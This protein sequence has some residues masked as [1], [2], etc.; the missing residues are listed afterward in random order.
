MPGPEAPSL[1][2][3][4]ENFSGVL[5]VVALAEDT[6]EVLALDG[7]RV[8]PTASVIK[9][10]ILAEVF[11]QEQAG[12]LSLSEPVTLGEA[13][14]AGGSGVLKDLSAGL[15]LP[16]L[17]YATLMITVSDNTATNMLIDRLGGIAA[18][19]R[20]MGEELGL[21]TITLRRK[22]TIAP[23]A[24][25][26][27]SRPPLGA[28]SPRQLAELVSLIWQRRLV[29]PRASEHMLA[30]L[31]RQQYLDQVP[32]LLDCHLLATQ[33]EPPAGIAV[34]NKT[35][36]ADGARADAGLLLLHGRAVSYAVMSASLDT[37]LHAD[38]DGMLANAAAGVAI[39]ER[40]WPGTGRPPVRAARAVG[41]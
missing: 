14:R 7:D 17:D 24:E 28:A 31:G 27:G 36:M 41:R 35:G 6:G 34:A 19:N 26:G 30:I 9:L 12:D 10:A 39:A 33:A 8:M 1:E 25:P 11:R 40:F 23:A 37:T 16:L 4:A 21:E 3:I 22:V 5:A 18:V 2:Q 15:T 13:N 29:S 20:F 38:H 32:R